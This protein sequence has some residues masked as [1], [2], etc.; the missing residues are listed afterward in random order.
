MKFAEPTKLRRKSGIW[1]TPRG[2]PC[3]FIPRLSSVVRR[4]DGPLFGV[5]EHDRE[6]PQK[7]S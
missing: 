5:E 2:T 7:R 4:T 1:G 3:G 6:R